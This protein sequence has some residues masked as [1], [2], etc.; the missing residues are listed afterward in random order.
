M[1]L[2]LLG[3]TTALTAAAVPFAVACTPAE[4]EPEVAVTSSPVVA[5]ERGAYYEFAFAPAKGFEN[6]M[7][8]LGD[9]TLAEAAWRRE[10][11]ELGA[12]NHATGA[13][14]GAALDLQGN[15]LEVEGRP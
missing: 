15:D 5:A 6:W 1:R 2:L 14:L 3:R 4:S 13:L 10:L 8:S 12:V 9:A 7:Q 11:A